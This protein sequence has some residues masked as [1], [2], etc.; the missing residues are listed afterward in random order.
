MTPRGAGT[1]RPPLTRASHG[2][3]VARKTPANPAIGS[4]PIGPVGPIL[5]H[6]LAPTVIT[7]S[8]LGTR[9]VAEPGLSK[10][11]WGLHIRLESDQSTQTD[12]ETVTATSSERF[13]LDEL[14]AQ[15]EQH[16][17]RGHRGLVRLARAWAL[18]ALATGGDALGS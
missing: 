18:A 10:P 2:T 6:R 1:T 17:E 8:A 14:Q 11:A 5:D 16:E 4:G 12:Q 15:R 13:L 9:I 3:C 7:R